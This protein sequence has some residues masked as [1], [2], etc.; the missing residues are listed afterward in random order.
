MHPSTQTYAAQNTKTQ[1]D[2]P[3]PC[4]PTALA[5][6][7]DTADRLRKFVCALEELADRM[8]G[9]AP[10]GSSGACAQGGGILEELQTSLGGVE[11]RLREVTAR[12]NRI[13]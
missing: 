3:A 10:T 12:L 11:S 8:F 1:M 6:A 9:P 5:D 4:A 13:A 7:L 2:C